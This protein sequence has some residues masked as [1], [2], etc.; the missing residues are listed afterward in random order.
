MNAAG[1]NKRG[2]T[3]VEMM[4]S[5]TIM[6]FVILALVTLIITTQSAHLTEGRKLDMNQGARMVEQML[7]DGFR[8]AGSVLS[9]A[10]TPALLGGAAL[11]FN[12]VYPLNNSGY[13]DGVIL[14]SGDPDALTRLTADFAPGSTLLNVMSVNLGDGSAVAWQQGDIGMIMRTDG[15]Y[16]FRVEDP[17]AMG[18]TELGIRNTAVYYSG[19]LNTAHYNDACDDQLGTLGNNGNYLTSI[20]TW[21]APKTTV[22][23]P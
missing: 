8:S 13:P 18:D 5:L 17:V 10:N 3:L 4:I 6:L 7:Y 2:F 23:A 9:L 19:L 16:V 20:S 21:S 12:G 22:R 1:M 15:Y 11:P 14:S